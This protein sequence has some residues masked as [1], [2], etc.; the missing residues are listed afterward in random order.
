MNPCS[1]IEFV[2]RSC[3]KPL[4]NKQKSMFKWWDSRAVWTW[5]L[6]WQS[7]N[8]APRT[9]FWT[10]GLTTSCS[11]NVLGTWQMLMHE[12]HVW[13]LYYAGSVLVSTLFVGKQFYW[14][15]TKQCHNKVYIYIIYI[16]YNGNPGCN[17]PWIEA[18]CGC[19]LSDIQLAIR[20]RTLN[21]FS[22][23]L[24]ILGQSNK[25][26]TNCIYPHS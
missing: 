8:W 11:N 19:L 16:W 13:S 24:R 21:A 1:C 22:T 3:L 23:K 9:M 18:C 4:S 5:I 26:H 17:Q 7:L 10:L 15:I 6:T 20:T 14:N 12:K 25:Y 2:D